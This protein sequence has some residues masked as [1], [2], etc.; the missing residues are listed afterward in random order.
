MVHVHYGNASLHRAI[1]FFSYFPFFL[2]VRPPLNSPSALPSLRK[3]PLVTSQDLVSTTRSPI[4][5]PA[6]PC[7]DF[8]SLC[9]FDFS[10]FGSLRC[11]LPFSDGGEFFLPFILPSPVFL[12]DALPFYV[13]RL[14]L[15]S[16]RSSSGFLLQGTFSR[17]PLLSILRLPFKIHLLLFLALSPPQ[18]F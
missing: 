13:L 7:L 14:G 1:S 8:K 5:S 2:L 6:L 15:D 12:F 11:R 16:R 3:R 18:I 10:M 4:F 9:D 17:A